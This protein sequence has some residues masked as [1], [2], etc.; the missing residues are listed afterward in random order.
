MDIFKKHILI[1]LVLLEARDTVL[2]ER[3]MG[4]RIDPDTGGRILL[5]IT[6]VIIYI[7][8][9]TIKLLT[10]ILENYLAVTPYKSQNKPSDHS[11][12]PQI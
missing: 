3:V 8:K 9:M 6:I 10:V 5:F 11:Y 7:N 4:K 12:I 2:I 1:I